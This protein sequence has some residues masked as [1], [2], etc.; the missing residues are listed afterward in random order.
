MTFEELMKGFE[1][2]RY[3]LKDTSIKSKETDEQ[4]AKRFKE[5]DEQIAKRFKETDKNFEE[6]RRHSKETYEQLTKLFKETDKQIK[7]TD[8]QIKETAIAFEE[9]K[10]ELQKGFD[11]TQKNVDQATMAVNNLTG[12]WGNFVVGLVLPAVERLF[13][14]RGIEVTQIAQN[15]KSRKK[16]FEMEIDILA[17]NGEYVALIEVKSTLKVDDVKEHIERLDKFKPAFPAYSDKKLVGAVAGIVIDS[18]ADRF[19]YKNGLFVIAQ[20]GDTVKFLN[21]NKFVPKEF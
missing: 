1:E 7:E 9:T 15:I 11:R 6:L 10:K 8:K 16:G 4:I 21:D 14:E 20:S 2:I 17:A 19:A 18:G 13:K 5:T 3:I 12:K